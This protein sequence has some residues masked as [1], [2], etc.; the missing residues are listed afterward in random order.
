[1]VISR[2]PFR[3][4]FF[5]G[6]T[7]Y[8][9][10]YEK[11]GGAVIGATI[12]K[13][14]YIT[15]RYLPPFFKYNYRIRYTKQEYKRRL[16]QIKH[17]SVRECLRYLG[18]QRGIEMQHNADVPAMSGLGSSSS[19]TV[20]FLNALYALQGQMVDK[21]KLA[22]D[23]IHVEQ[24]MIGESVGSQDQTLVSH[25]GLNKIVFGAREI[26]VIPITISQKSLDLL[27][28]HLMLFFTGMTR[29]ASDVARE[30]IKAT[31][32]K[33]RELKA[34]LKLVDE[35]Y[36]VLSDSGDSLDEFGRFLHASWQLKR[37][38]TKKISNGIIDEIYETA[39]AAGALGG[40]LLGAGG[41]G[42]MLFYVKPQYQPKVKE[43][44]KR[45]L[46]VP[47]KFEPHGSQ[48]IYKMPDDIYQ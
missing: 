36:K 9:V 21:K 8:P 39:L 34:M 3:I 42:F 4:S 7:D 1:M 41:G 46:F 25:G 20:G 26:N 17:P 19:F 35:A 43:A 11:H 2:T 29:R 6:G 47:F 28:D 37:R 10:W 33:T 12:N 27:Q 31:H 22:L 40:K 5:G 15:C 14:C 38:L 16:E 30:Q 24:E 32:K 44:L 45:L 13:Y 48:I 23:A 18:I